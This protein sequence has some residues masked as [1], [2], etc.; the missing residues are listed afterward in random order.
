VFIDE[1]LVQSRLFEIWL[2]WLVAINS[3]SVVFVLVSR[4]ARWV[5]V[6]WLVHIWSLVL[7][8]PLL[9]E[10]GYSRFVGLSQIVIWT[11]L[12]IYLSMRL[13]QLD[14]SAVSSKYI[15]ILFLSNLIAL[16][17]DYR[18]FILWLLGERAAQL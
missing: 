5:L 16:T 3:I 18:A 15:A 1:I 17:L 11:P 13:R 4:E 6:L 14:W 8:K 10:I 2:W 12:L 9:N 7:I